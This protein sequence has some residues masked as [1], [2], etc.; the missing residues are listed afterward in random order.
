V[1]AFARGDR[2][3]SNNPPSVTFN[4]FYSEGYVLEPGSDAE[5]V[6]A[7]AHRAATGKEL[8]SF[9]TAGYLDARVYALYDKIPALCYGPISQNIHGSDER[10]SLA[11]LKRI[12][13]AMALFIAGWCG[14][15]ACAS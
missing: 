14:V 5:A 7:K 11:S 1:A 6:L 15:E 4:G 3:L 13:T 10:V 8:Q 9:M 12:T 2:F